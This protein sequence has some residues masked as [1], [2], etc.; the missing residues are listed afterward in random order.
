MRWNVLELAQNGTYLKL[1]RGFAVVMQDEHELGKVTLDELCCVLLSAQQTTVSKSIMVEL[2]ERGIPLIVCG[3]NFMPISISLPIAANHATTGVLFK[4]IKTSKPANKRLWKQIVEQKIKHQY[5]VLKNSC[6][7]PD[8][9]KLAQLKRLQATVKSGDPENCEAQA[10]R[11]YWQSLFNSSFRRKA[12]S[13]D[14]LNSALNYGYAIIRAATA[15]A[16]CAAG[17]NPSLGL[18]HKNNKN[19]FCLADDLMELYRPLVDYQV[20]NTIVDDN[21]QL[22]PATKQSLAALLKADIQQDGKITTVTTSMNRLAVSLVKCIYGESTR[23]LLPEIVL[24]EE[25]F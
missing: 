8:K 22:D 3:S 13:Q 20:K 9:A 6:Q 19:S 12:Q 23:L 4:Q 18:H 5:L 1:F 14:S 11:I 21:Q 24:T 25:G 16:I 7:H 10:A 15:R 17:L 2:A